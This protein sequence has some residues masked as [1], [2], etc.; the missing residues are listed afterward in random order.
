M[1]VPCRRCDKM[2]YRETK[3]RKICDYCKQNFWI[4]HA[5]RLRK[6]QLDKLFTKEELKILKSKFYK[7]G[8]SEKNAYEKIKKLIETTEKNNK[9]MKSKSPVL[10]KTKIGG[11]PSLCLG[12]THIS[13]KF[14]YPT[15]EGK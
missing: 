12:E 6:H 11:T 2:F 5:Q 15:E 7:E 14:I 4:K 8:M 10:S 13:S 9:K 3:H 1:N